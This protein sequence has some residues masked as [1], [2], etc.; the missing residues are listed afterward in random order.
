M[1]INMLIVDDEAEIREMLSRHFRYRGFSVDTAGNGEE[2]LQVLATKKI[3]LVISDI[4]MPVMDGPELCG[5]IRQDYPLTKVIIITGHVSLDNA[6][7]CLRRGAE[8]CIFKPIEDMAELEEAVN[9]SV[10]SIKRWVK[11]LTEL[12]GVRP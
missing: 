3:D 1:M 9:R 10:D 12:K 2:A 8:T 4:L 7:T 11:I 5:R 6:M